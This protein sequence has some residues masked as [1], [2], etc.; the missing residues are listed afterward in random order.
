MMDKTTMAAPDLPLVYVIILSWKQRDYTLACLASLS[1][2]EYSRHRIVVVD[3]GSADGSPVLIEERFPKVILIRNERNLGFCEGN[4]M[5]IRHAL[6]HGAD[7]VL[8]LNS[9]TE[10]DPRFLTILVETAEA[11]ER[12]G[13]AGPMVCYYDDPQRIWSAGGLIEGLAVPRTLRHNQIDDGQ[14]EAVMD[15]DYVAGCALLVKASVIQHIGLLDARFFAYHEDADWC[16][17]ARMAGFRVVYVPQARVWHKVSPGAR[18][19]SPHHIYFM[20][21]NRLLFLKKYG[22]TFLAIGFVIVNGY[23][24]TILSWSLRPEHR[25]KR[26][27]RAAILRGVCDFLRGRFGPPPA[28]VWA[29]ESGSLAN[30]T[31]SCHSELR[32]ARSRHSLGKNTPYISVILRSGFCD[33]E[34]P[35]SRRADSSA[36]PGSALE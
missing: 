25:H 3:N 14:D 16:T 34:S 1:Q 35:P 5:G 22:G 7:Y 30:P 9:D 21:R 29:S 2:L 19:H 31:L 26:P 10:V 15:L 6:Q 17:R 11:D 27:L 4:N 28:S 24:R 8:L 33:E 13:M 20:T 23:L 18:D 12:I 36:P 32:M